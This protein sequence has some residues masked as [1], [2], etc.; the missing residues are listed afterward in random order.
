MKYKIYAQRVFCFHWVE[1]VS[2]YR[3]I[4][5]LPITFENEDMGWAEFDLGGAS[6]AIERQCQKSM[7]AQSLVGRFVGISIQVDD[8][9]EIYKELVGKG[10]V[11]SHPPEKQPWGGVLAHF[12]D[13][14][15][16]TITLLGR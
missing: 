12:N 6:L 7:E 10:V 3:D 8:I 5:G 11:F 16:N 13:P 2:F 15:G 4:I 1:C 9:E 14:D